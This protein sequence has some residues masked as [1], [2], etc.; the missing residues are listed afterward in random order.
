VD[1]VP[2]PLPLATDHSSAVCHA[3]HE[4]ELLVLADERAEEAE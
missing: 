1:D 4:H 3:V 2:Q